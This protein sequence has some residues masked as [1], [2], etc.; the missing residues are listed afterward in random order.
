MARAKIAF[1]CSS[2]VWVQGRRQLREIGGAKLKS[3]GQGF[4]PNFSGRNHRCSPT[5]KRS[6]PKS[7]G[8]FWPKLQILTF[9][10]PNNSNFFLP[11]NSVGGQEKNRG[12]KNENRGGIAP[13]PPAGDAPVWV[14]CQDRLCVNTDV[15]KTLALW[16]SRHVSEVQSHSSEKRIRFNHK[17]CIFN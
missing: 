8:F 2:M 3:G 7:E 6:S 5:K 1:V 10:P 14:S 9:F 15:D 13:P 16:E 4:S 12:D 17:N 11:K